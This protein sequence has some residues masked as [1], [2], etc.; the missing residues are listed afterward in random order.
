[1]MRR[2]Q[3]SSYSKSLQFKNAVLCLV[4]LLL[5]GRS[6]I[7]TAVELHASMLGRDEV[8]KM[9]TLA[10]DAICANGTDMCLTFLLCNVQE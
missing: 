1:M 2:N 7:H 8:A 3:L 6:T 10:P 5:L 9:A 4:V